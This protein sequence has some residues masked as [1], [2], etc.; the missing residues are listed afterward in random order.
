[1]FHGLISTLER[2]TET[3]VVYLTEECMR[4]A[5]V[6]I[7]VD[8]PRCFSELNCTQ[9]FTEYLVESQ[10]GNTILFEIGLNQLVK[11]LDSGKSSSQCQLKLVK[12]NGKSCLCFETKAS[13]SVISVDLVHDMPIRLMRSTDIAHHMPPQVTSPLVALQLPRTKLMKTIIDKMMKF[14]KSVHMEAFQSG[15]LIF[16]VDHS[17]ASIKTYYNGLEPVF[18]GDLEP[19][20]HMDNRVAVKLNLRRLSAV[21]NFSSLS[22]NNASLFISDE[23][24]LVHVTLNPPTLGTLTFYLPIMV[25]LPGDD[26]NFAAATPFADT[27]TAG[28][29]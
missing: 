14:S 10:A 18:V 19:A 16:S 28:A 1:M 4:L 15:R 11:A 2:L 27:G 3:V 5:V 26:A 20:E 12:R 13:E 22:Y 24:V 29:L 6:T 8:T 21:I 9:L 17:A 7:G 25:L 23:S